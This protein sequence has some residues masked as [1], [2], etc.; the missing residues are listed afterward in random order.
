MSPKTS[1]CKSL[2]ETFSFILNMASGPFLNARRGLTIAATAC[3]ASTRASLEFADEQSETKL[4]SLSVAQDMHAFMRY[5]AAHWLTHL[6]A[7]VEAC[8][9]GWGEIDNLLRHQVTLLCDRHQRLLIQRPP[10]DPALLDMTPA[11][12]RANVF[13]GHPALCNLAQGVWAI[14]AALTN[15]CIDIDDGKIFPPLQLPNR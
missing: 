1:Y 7:L 15:R 5:S 9:G 13:A 3:V 11:R 10:R 2:T 12:D 8:K 4:L 14:E 6:K